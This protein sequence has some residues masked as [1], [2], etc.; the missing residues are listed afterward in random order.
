[1]AL[2]IITPS[3]LLME[4]VFSICTNLEFSRFRSACSQRSIRFMLHL[5]LQLPQGYFELILVDQ[6]A[7]RV[8]VLNTKRSRGCSAQCEQGRLCL[9]ST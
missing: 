5:K 1:M 9:E 8:P 3:D 6:Q 4:F 7:E 2:A